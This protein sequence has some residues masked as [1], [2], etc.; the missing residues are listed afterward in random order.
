[1]TNN[2]EVMDD[3]TALNERVKAGLATFV[4]VGKALSTIREQKLYKAGGY[5]TFEQY[6]AEEHGF[7]ARHGRRM[8]QAARVESLAPGISMQAATALATVPEQ[9]RAEVVKRATDRQGKTPTGE[10]ISDMHEEVKAERTP[11]PEAE[12]GMTE[13]IKQQFREAYAAVQRARTLV[14][15]LGDEKLGRLLDVDAC[16]V[17]LNNTL[18]EIKFA[19]PKHRCPYCGGEGCKHCKHCGMLSDRLYELVAEELKPE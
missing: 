6:T 5:A 16:R 12:V 14:E 7:S 10:M 9:D 4:E 2:I 17:H 1:M 8:I 18:E 19:V 3:F 15:H 11:E 13:Q